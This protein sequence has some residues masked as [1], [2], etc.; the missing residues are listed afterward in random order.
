MQPAQK[1]GNVPEFS[2]GE[3]SLALKKTVESAFER[4]RVRG[5]I[6]G[7]S[8]PASGHVYFKLKDQD[9]VIDA[10]CWKFS[11]PKLAL[12][13]EDGLEIV[14]TGKISTYPGNSRY[15]IIVDAIEMAGI[16]A[17]LKQLEERK[18][19]LAAEGLFD[20][21]RK[22]K[23]P[24]LPRSI[25]V[26][27]S[28]TGAVIR[29]ILHRLQDRFPRPVLLWPV[30][31]QGAGAAEQIAAAIEGFNALSENGA[32]ARPDVLIVARGGGSIEDLWEFNSEIVVRAAA[33]S[34]IPLISAV[35]HETDFTL[36]D[37]AADLRAPTPT[38][39]AELAVPVKMQLLSDIAQ[40]SS[41]IS[42]AI[43]RFLAN[44]RRALQNLARALPHPRQNIALL[45]QNL[46]GKSIRLKQSL[47]AYVASMRARFSALH[48]S[49]KLLR[50]ELTQKSQKLDF[51]KNRLRQSA[52]QIIAQ[53][54][55]KLDSASALLQSLSYKNVLERGFAV[56]RSESGEVIAR[57]RQWQAGE[58]YI[59]EFADGK[60]KAK[61]D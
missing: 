4:V 57:K 42:S 20:E 12:K 6:S 13:P 45:Q 2:V 21:S 31:V 44:E 51:L 35:G 32:V 3:I 50:Q 1:P 43:V 19:K 16:G 27:T 38:A 39:A 59:V 30:P 61:A 22:K 15:Q 8:R 7:L 29:D 48:L 10:V 25:G 24:F 53:Q 11:L 56:V 40:K 58:E 26:I 5:E 60:A 47:M 37:F 36:I 28:P 55:Q 52:A 33:A 49:P 18:K 34:K 46:D 54:K 23:I 17:L 14:A 9:A 41:R